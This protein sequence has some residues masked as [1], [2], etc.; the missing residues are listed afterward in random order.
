MGRAGVAGRVPRYGGTLSDRSGLFGPCP[1][2]PMTA[3]G[4][5]VRGSGESFEAEQARVLREERRVILPPHDL[6]RAEARIAR[7]RRRAA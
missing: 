4:D 7:R 6:L 1:R 2:H 5:E 3:L